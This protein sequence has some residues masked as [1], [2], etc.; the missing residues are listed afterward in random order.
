[1]SRKLKPKAPL[2]VFCGNPCEQWHPT[3][4]GYGNN[5]Q[6]LK[7]EGRC[8]KV[9]NDRYV[10][11]ARIAIM[12]ATRRGI[13]TSE[14][15]ADVCRMFDAAGVPVDKPYTEAEIQRSQNN[16]ERLFRAAGVPL[17]DDEV[18]AERAAKAAQ[19]KADAREGFDD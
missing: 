12:Q 19:R 8:C 5:P 10:I 7:A 1:M 4:D 18:E 3:S 6:P 9:C 2:C 16:I 13:E 11:A 17:T 15:V 14:A